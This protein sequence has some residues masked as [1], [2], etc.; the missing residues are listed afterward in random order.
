MGKIIERADKKIIVPR[1]TVR[2]KLHGHTTIDLFNVRTKKY[3]RVEHDNMFNTAA[4]ENMFV[5]TG[6]GESAINVLRGTSTILGQFFGGIYLFDTALPTNPAPLYMP[7]GTTMVANASSLYTGTGTPRELGLYNTAESAST[8]NSATFV[9]DWGTSQGNGEIA[10]V[11]LASR[12]GGFIGYGNASGGFYPSSADNP[13]DV[14]SGSNF[15][16]WTYTPPTAVNP[17]CTYTV[18][19]GCFYYTGDSVGSGTLNPTLKRIRLPIKNG[20]ISVFSDLF[21]ANTPGDT[22]TITLPSA[23]SA[24]YW[25]FTAMDGVLMILCISKGSS[26]GNGSSFKF[27]L[28][29]CITETATEHTVTNLSGTSISSY[30]IYVLDSTYMLLV[31]GSRNCYLMNYQNNTLVGKADGTVS[32]WN[33][34]SISINGNQAGSPRFTVDGGLYAFN[35]CLYDRVLNKVRPTNAY[36]LRPWGETPSQYLWVQETF[37]PSL[38]RAIYHDYYS[39]SSYHNYLYSKTSWMHLLT[40]N[41]LDNPVTKTADKTMKVTYTIMA[42]S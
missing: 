7:A 21:N 42:A 10:S 24:G 27:Y 36:K 16:A 28:I 11:S 3:E 34:S 15:S 5:D 39:S 2:E 8:D 20:E 32:N 23:T 13:P 22:V 26:V 12:N 33:N 38:N 1:V 18:A 25:A 19:N 14:G 29:D 4:F 31:D 17:W 6:F 40:I 37:S 9:F 30:R 35:G 41:N